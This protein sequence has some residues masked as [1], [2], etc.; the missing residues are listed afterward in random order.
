MNEVIYNKKGVSIEKFDC[1]TAG[2]CYQIELINEDRLGFTIG[3]AQK[4]FRGEEM[5][6]LVADLVELRIGKEKSDN[7]VK[8]DLKEGGL[9]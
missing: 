5:K 4:R 6:E 3:I 1:G 9:K 2:I 7:K 8:E